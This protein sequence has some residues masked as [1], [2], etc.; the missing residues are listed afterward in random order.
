MILVG[1]LSSPGRVLSHD[2]ADNR[3]PAYAACD[4]LVLSRADRFV[5]PW[6]RVPNARIDHQRRASWPHIRPS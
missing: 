2:R 6:L 1:G 3:A 4:G 5:T